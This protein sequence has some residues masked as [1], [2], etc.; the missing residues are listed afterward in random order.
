MQIDRRAKPV[1]KQLLIHFDDGISWCTRY[2][3]VCNRYCPL[4]TVVT[5]KFMELGQMRY[6]ILFEQF[7]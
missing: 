6:A 4:V 7:L 1:Q 5:V 3:R 2:N